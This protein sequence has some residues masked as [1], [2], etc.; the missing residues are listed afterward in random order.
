MPSSCIITCDNLQLP[1]TG[2]ADQAAASLAW[3]DL[4]RGCIGAFGRT[5]GLEGVK[6]AS[7]LHDSPASAQFIGILQATARGLAYS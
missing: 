3:Q 2:I 1:V 4:D 7:L 5:F 6:S